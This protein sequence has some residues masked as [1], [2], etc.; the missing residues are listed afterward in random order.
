MLSDDE[1]TRIEEAC[2][3]VDAAE[4]FTGVVNEK[5]ALAMVRE[6]R[7]LRGRVKNLAL[8]AMPPVL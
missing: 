5:V 4:S 8:K 1:L 3:G 2:T 7:S 6:I